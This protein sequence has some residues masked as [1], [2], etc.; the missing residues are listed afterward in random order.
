MDLARYKELGYNVDA[1]TDLFEVSTGLADDFDAM[2]V[3][4][5]FAYDASYNQGQSMLCHV[6]LLS[7]DPEVGEQKVMYSTGNGWTSPDGGKTIIHE[8]NRVTFNQ[9]SNYG[10][11]IKRLVELD[12]KDL[13]N[14][15]GI[16]PFDSGMLLGAKFHW[17]RE[18]AE[19]LNF[20]DG[21]ADDGKLRTRLLPTAFLGFATEEEV[22]K[23]LAGYMDFGATPSPSAAP[24]ATASTASVAAPTAPSATAGL[25]P[26]IAAQLTA[27][28]KAS[29]S[30][31]EF[32]KLAVAAIPTLAT[33]A[34]DTFIK[35]ISPASGYWAQLK[36]A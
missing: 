32:A 30:A 28:A 29:P 35:V 20:G 2:V 25:D 26:A 36:N 17:K 3:E 31:E 12:M 8:R 10:K 7:P 22:N 9:T 19:K 5:R 24:A 14:S 13:L 11:L 23:A 1:N 4:A 33:A 6:T 18:E 15:R 21:R 27:I 16:A 34:R